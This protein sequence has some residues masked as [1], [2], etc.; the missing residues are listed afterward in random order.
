TL[1]LA[2]MVLGAAVPVAAQPSGGQA[3]LDYDFFKA[4]VLPILTTKRD[5][6]ARCISCHGSGTPMRLQPLADRA[7]TWRDPDARK[8][9]EL[10]SA[11]VVPGDPDHSRLLTHPLAEEAGGDPHHDGGK[12]WTSKSDPEW[13]TLAA[14]ARGDTL[15]ASARPLALSPRIV[16][17]N[18]A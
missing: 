14:W 9:F 12:H 5:G 11:R 18:S 1:L 2:T 10:M 3:K 13:Q 4:R 15:A 7:P 6:N 17:T 8:H 16:Q